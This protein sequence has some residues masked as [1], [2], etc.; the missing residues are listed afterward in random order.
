[1]A[2]QFTVKLYCTIDW[3]ARLSLVCPNLDRVHLA[4]MLRCGSQAR[5]IPHPRG[6]HEQSVDLLKV[7]MKNAVL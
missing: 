4:P 3:T 1:M 2:V 7:L 5:M 6:L